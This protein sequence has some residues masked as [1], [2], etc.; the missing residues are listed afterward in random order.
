VWVLEAELRPGFSHRY[1]KRVFYVDEDSWL[2]VLE[3]MYDVRDQFWRTAEAHVINF[4]DVPVVINGLQVH[5]DLQS[6][7]YVVINLTNEEP[8]IEYDFDRDPDYYTPQ[9]LQRFATTGTP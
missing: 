7:R 3:D 6:R 2:V 8:M 1:K 4:S 5:Y 9:Q